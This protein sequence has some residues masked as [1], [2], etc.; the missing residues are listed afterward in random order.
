MISATPASC[1]SETPHEFREQNGSLIYPIATKTPHK[2]MKA[3]RVVKLGGKAGRAE[4]RTAVRVVLA[5]LALV[6]GLPGACAQ[7]LPRSQTFSVNAPLNDG[8][9][10]GNEFLGTTSLFGDLPGAVVYDLSVQLDITGGFNG[11]LYAYL[12]KDNGFAVLLNRVGRESGNLDGFI[13]PGLSV[14]FSDS[15]ANGDV[16]AYA[17]HNLGTALTGTWQPDGR[18][19][20]PSL[21]LGGDLRTADLGSF[22]DQPADGMWTL[23]IEDVVTGQQATM[24]SWTLTISSVP[25]PGTWSLA[26]GVALGAFTWVRHIRRHPAPRSR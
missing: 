21:T 16:H 7:S 10:V 3:N 12:A 9:G 26:A 19:T 6:P 8:T 2:L 4:V 23:Y 13:D 22:R 24:N 17:P 25:E 18:E 14:T 11:Q 15:A 5:A 20:D 1:K